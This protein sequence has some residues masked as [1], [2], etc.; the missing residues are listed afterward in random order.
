M[1]TENKPYADVHGDGQ[2]SHSQYSETTR[3]L[4]QQQ[5][6]NPSQGYPVYPPNMAGMP[7][8]YY[9]P[10]PEVGYGGGYGAPNASLSQQPPQVIVVAPAFYNAGS[11]TGAIVYSCFV[12]WL[13]N[14]PFGL[15]AFI[16]A[17]EYSLRWSNRLLLTCQL[18]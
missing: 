7:Q 17:S 8:P 9:V 2:G 4:Q 10:P 3:L 6:P 13:W 11:F 12:F 18:I 5:Q 15:A 1:E 16:L 14:L